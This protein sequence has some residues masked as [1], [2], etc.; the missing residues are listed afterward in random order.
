MS[1][2]LPRGCSMLRIRVTRACTSLLQLVALAGLLPPIA[3]ASESDQDRLAQGRELFLREW[4]PGDSRSHGGDGLGPLYNETSCVACHSLGGPGGAG[5]A[6]KNVDIVTL[7]R[8]RAI[9]GSGKALAG[10]ELEE[11]HPGFTSSP[12]VMLHRFGT[13]P[14]YRIWRL[15][16][17]AGVEFADMAKE[18]GAREMEQVREMVGLR[19]GDPRASAF[20]AVR[21]NSRG[22]NRVTGTALLSTVST[23]TRR[24]SP[25][26]FGAGLID[27]I[28]AE[29]IR[30]AAAR[31]IPQ[32]PEIKGRPAVLKDGRVGRF[33]WK[34]QTP[35]LKEFVESAC[36]MELGL[37][38]P[39]HHQ[40]R[41]P[42]DFTKKD[43]GLDLN[44]DECDALTSYVSKLPAPIER[45]APRTKA[46]ADS[47]AGRK[48]FDKVG[49]TACHMAKLGK[50]E[51]IFSDLLLHDMGTL[52][53]DA[54][55]YY[56][57][58]ESPSSE[59]A[60]S[61]EWKTPPLWGCRDSGPYLHDGRADT[62]EEAIALHGGQGEHSAKMYFQLEM[63]E[64]FQI[65]SFLNSLAA[66][67]AD[68]GQ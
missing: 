56:G 21:P 15:K 46:P 35:S 4:V 32:F 50:V 43:N 20:S 60:K 51:G 58:I 2:V 29:D 38:V 7:V 16:R 42:L 18:G 57:S 10:A 31:P 25:A 44:G 61:Q 11:F 22:L 39:T 37:E 5:S 55:S 27:S 45:V 65:Q 67:P 17:V 3:G 59:G 26:L 62:L 40:A 64:R 33:G 34:S 8:G 47:V 14:E 23:L 54:G 68:R 53:A 36:A 49:C 30:A 6:S 24:N 9:R 1:Q 41:P 63:R 13:D 66:P 48:L 52:L 12:S 28:P 19:P